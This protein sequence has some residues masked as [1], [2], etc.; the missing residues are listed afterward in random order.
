MDGMT[1]N[2][3][4]FFHSTDEMVTCCHVACVSKTQAEDHCRALNDALR[5]C[6][7]ARFV[8]TVINHDQEFD[9]LM[10]EAEDKLSVRTNCTNPSDHE[11]M[12]EHANCTLKGRVQTQCNLSPCKTCPRF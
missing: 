10:D 5:E 2:G 8:V 11:P 1:V 4:Q 9:P 12:I 3:M 6:N 7:E